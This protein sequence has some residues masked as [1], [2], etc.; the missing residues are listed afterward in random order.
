LSVR[1]NIRIQAH[2]TRTA[3]VENGGQVRRAFKI[4]DQTWQL[5]EVW[6][7]DKTLPN[8]P[9][10]TRCLEQWRSEDLYLHC[11]GADEKRALRAV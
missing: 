9:P 6:F 7:E 3:H 4:V 11:F 8:Q 1:R 2:A 5:L 10:R